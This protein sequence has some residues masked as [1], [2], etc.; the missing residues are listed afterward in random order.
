M[1]ATRLEQERD[2][3]LRLLELGHQRELLPLLEEALGMAVEAT[4]ADCG[5]L[6]IYAEAPHDS[7][8]LSM[9]H[10]LSDSDIEEIRQQISHSII[11]KALDH[12]QVIRTP[13]ASE[14]PAFADQPSVRLGAIG[15]VLCVPLGTRRPLG[16]LYL[17]RRRG[18]APFLDGDVTLARAFCRHVT[19]F[20]NHLLLLENTLIKADYTRE[21]RKSISV[22]G[23][24]GRS[25]AIASVLRQ[26]AQVAPHDVA[27]LITGAPGTGKT[28]VARAIHDNGPRANHPFVAINCATLTENLA[29]AELFGAM[30]GA[31]STAYART[32]GKIDAAAKGT[33]FLDEVAEM[34]LPVQGKLLKLLD[35]KIFFPLGSSQARTADVRII[36]AT[37]ADLRQ[38]VRERCFREDLLDRLEVFPIHMPD[39]MDRRED[40]PLLVDHFLEQFDDGRQ[41]T[42]RI[43]PYALDALQT[44]PLSGN[45]RKLKNYV[46]AGFIRARAD[47]ADA[48]QPWHLF[49]ENGADKPAQD[50]AQLGYREATRAFQRRL[51]SQALAATEWN[52]AAAARRLRLKRPHLHELIRRHG[53]QRPG[54]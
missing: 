7:S 8:E 45:V 54:A 32:Y 5:Y 35:S 10:G 2:L 31:H 18:L 1:D 21:L 23:L 17:Q 48:I 50:P 51:L 39:I 40:I 46:H 11:A 52:V 33:L 14:D 9:A 49:P 53:L 37:N 3:Y 27:V 42:L 16:V 24:V 47:R 13:S 12:N 25:R 6:E 19:P 29:E 30:R 4:A 34:L 38:R 26:I 22:V 15:A 43:S 28:V 20:V 44:R 41:P 36:C